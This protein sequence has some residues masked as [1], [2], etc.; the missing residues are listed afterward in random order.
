M[1][2]C[3]SVR[4]LCMHTHAYPCMYMPMHALMHACLQGGLGACSSLREAY[5]G[6]HGGGLGQSWYFLV[7]ILVGVGV[8]LVGT[9][10]T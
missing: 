6:C 7:G 8:G 4:M 10:Y 2:F 1:A 5:W 9:I 3:A